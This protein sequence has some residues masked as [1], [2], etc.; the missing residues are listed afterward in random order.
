MVRIVNVRFLVVAYGLKHVFEFTQKNS[1]SFRAGQSV[2]GGDEQ[3]FFS[4]MERIGIS[5]GTDC[6]RK[7]IYGMLSSMTC[8]EKRRSTCLKSATDSLSGFYRIL[9]WLFWVLQSEITPFSFLLVYQWTPLKVCLIPRL[10]GCCSHQKK[11]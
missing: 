8:L 10:P 6:N 2:V 11:G 1:N 5:V 7:C 9:S 4:C 3:L